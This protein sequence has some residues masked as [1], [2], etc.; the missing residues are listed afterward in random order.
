[1]CSE[2]GDASGSTKVSTSMT[3][4]LKRQKRVGIIWAMFWTA[5]G[6]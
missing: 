3:K 6:E 5:Q 1:M 2:A 4:T